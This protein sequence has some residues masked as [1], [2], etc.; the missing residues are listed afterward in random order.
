[1]SFPVYFRLGPL[2][3]HPHWVFESLAYT[4]GF[5]LYRRHRR[6]SGDVI[7]PRARAWVIAAAAVGGMAGSRLLSAFEDPF[8]LAGHWTQPH[9]FLS[10][11][12]IVGGLI[13][14]LLAVEAVKRLL[15][16]RVATGDLLALP[17]VLGIAIGRIGCFLSGLEDQSY[18]VTTRLPWGVD[19]GDGVARHP[20]QLYEMIFLAGLAAVLLLRTT[21]MTTTG[22]RF[23]LFLLGYLTFRLLVDAI[24]PAVRVGGLSAI[25]WACLAVVAYYAPHVPRLVT[26]VRRG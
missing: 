23:K 11:K 2:A 9:L 14:G 15:G 25:Q 10:G 3:V 21:R 18:G 6:R 20:T 24:K 7:E 19:F 8:L 4:A 22:D 5:F 16:I 1:M 17:L 12:T 26:A 13:G